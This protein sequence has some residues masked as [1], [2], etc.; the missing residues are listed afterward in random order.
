MYLCIHIQYRNQ[1]IFGRGTSKQLSS[2]ADL[3]CLSR[4]RLFSIP[5]PNFFHPGSRI[6]IKEF[7]YLNPKN[8]FLSS[9][10]YDPGCSFWIP[11]PDL[12]PDFFPIPV[13]GSR[14]LK[15]TRSWIRIRN[16]GLSAADLAYGLWLLQG[17][18]DCGAVQRH[19][20]TSSGEASRCHPQST[21][22]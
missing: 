12:D 10:K 5:D 16:T 11:D 22:R 20:R 17:G 8:Y 13:P 19:S 15:G 6:H 7:K 14:G 1:D 3:G 2:F 21:C 18:R 9:W 4:I